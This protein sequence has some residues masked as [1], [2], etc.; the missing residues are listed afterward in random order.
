MVLILGWLIGFLPAY[1]RCLSLPWPF[2]QKDSAF[3]P[4][5]IR[6]GQVTS[7]GQW[8][9]SSVQE[10]TLRALLDLPYVFSFCHNVGKVPVRG[11]FITGSPGKDNVKQ[12]QLAYRGHVTWARSKHLVVSHW[13]YR[14]VRYHGKPQ[15]ILT[16]TVCFI[17]HT[18]HAQDL[19]LF[20]LSTY[21]KHLLFQK[22]IVPG[23]Q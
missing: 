23:A 8:N 11:C 20:P 17:K 9:V 12:L 21:M 13:D 10:E 5:D 15:P 7:F 16:D 3:L 4:I 14:I 1:I 2:L 19:C 22:K 18:L 6:L